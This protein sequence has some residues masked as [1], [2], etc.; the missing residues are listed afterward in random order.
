MPTDPRSNNE[1]SP[2]SY[3]S[4][5]DPINSETA[6]SNRLSIIVNKI[7]PKMKFKKRHYVAIIFIILVIILIIVFLLLPKSSNLI[8]KYENKSNFTNKDQFEDPISNDY[9][10]H[11]L[12]EQM[13]YNE[14]TPT[15]KKKY[16]NLPQA[17]KEQLLIDYLIQKI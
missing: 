7:K 14:F 6:P 16:L 1:E 3:V 8:S 15:D 10:I 12:V 17:L 5:L 11:Y 13:V 9:D 4:R 2:S